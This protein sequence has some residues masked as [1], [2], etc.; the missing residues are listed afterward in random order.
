[1]YL[2]TSEGVEQWTDAALTFFAAV[3]GGSA[4]HNWRAALR[5]DADASVMA[6]VGT[7][8][9]ATS[10]HQKAL[11]R[12]VHSSALCRRPP[13][14]WDEPFVVPES[15]ELFA[16]IVERSWGWTPAHSGVF[17]EKNDGFV[18]SRLPPARDSP[19]AAAGSAR[20]SGNWSSAPRGCGL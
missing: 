13:R 3:V 14:E 18:V 20:E 10:A 5:A 19:R 8:V 15:V 2:D 9:P 6:V 7:A 11:R 16:A 12:A 17:R 4:V 1:M